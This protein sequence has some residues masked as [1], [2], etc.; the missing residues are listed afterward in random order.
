M[1]GVCIKVLVLADEIGSTI[2]LF[3]KIEVFVVLAALVVFDKGSDEG[4]AMKL[5]VD[6]G[7]F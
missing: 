3:A 5:P 6:T 7:V 1:T 4:G 2:P